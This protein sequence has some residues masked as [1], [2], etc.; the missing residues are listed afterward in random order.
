MNPFL[1]EIYGTR[2]TI[3]APDPTD[4]VEKLA[5]C[6]LVDEFLRA[7]NIN[8][9][10][11]TPEQIVKVAHNLFGD[12]SEIVKAAMAA[13][14]TAPAAPTA[15]ATVA[16]TAPATAAPA[17]AAV[18]TAAAAPAA[19]PE[20]ETAEEKLADADF[21]GRVM[22]HSFTQERAEIE[23]QAAAEAS[24][25]TPVATTEA[26]ATEKTA[27]EMA[28]EQLA[29]EADLKG[30]AGK[31]GKWVKKPF[32]DFA[33]RRHS[34]LRT[35]I[36]VH[37][38]TY[39]AKPDSVGD[40]LKHTIKHNKGQTAAAIGTAAALTGGTAAAVHHA[41][42]EH[43]ASALDTLAEKR[44]MEILAENGIGQTEEEKLASAVEQ[45][46]YEMLLENGFEVEAE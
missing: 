37:G 6:Q 26:P 36:K 4:D 11:L 19:E 24:A 14:M 8:V 38:H 2:E 29:K 34:E 21:L 9:D 22:A 27:E 41:G 33:K 31:A 25:Q 46:A 30:L 15:P 32:E 17:P 1:A 13:Q 20:G 16:P 42:K 44:A 10:T 39:G 40:A 43:D 35:K 7:E 28:A 23:K 3:G 5:E 12:N 45:R 18:K